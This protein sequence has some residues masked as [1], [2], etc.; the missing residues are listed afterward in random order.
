L[1]HN[2]K[3]LLKQPDKA[4]ENVSDVL[5]DTAIVKNKDPQKPI[6]IMC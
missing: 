3:N 6:L 5:A 2:K 1:A 4:L